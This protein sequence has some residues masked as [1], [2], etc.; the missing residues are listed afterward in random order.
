M[1]L[2]ICITDVINRLYASVYNYVCG[3]ELNSEFIYI[4]SRPL[5]LAEIWITCASMKQMVG[6][7]VPKSV[8][9]IPNVNLVRFHFQIVLKVTIQMLIQWMIKRKRKSDSHLVHY[10]MVKKMESKPSM[11]QSLRG[12]WRVRGGITER[13][14]KVQELVSMSVTDHNSQRDFM[15][16]Q[17]TIIGLLRLHF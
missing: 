6:R 17:H 9:A 12:S 8:S 14:I 7:V 3:S 15:A 2:C 1:N 10:Q 4:S 13:K 16:P 5:N 11:T